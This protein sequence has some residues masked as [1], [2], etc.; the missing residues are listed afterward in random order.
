MS[1]EAQRG[2]KSQGSGLTARQEYWL[3]LYQQYHEE[4]RRYFAR[5]VTCSHDVDD[6]MQMVFLNVIAHRGDLQN[7]HAYLHAMARHQL[8]FYW[9]CRSRSVLM[10]R[11][12]FRGP[13]DS[14]EE[15]GPCDRDS[16]PLHQLSHREMHRVIDARIDGL[17]PALRE[18]L[19]LRYVDGLP[20]RAAAT[21]A[22]CSRAALKKRLARAKRLLLECFHTGGGRVDG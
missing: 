2:E 15:T 14:A 6:L 17:S 3:R 16:D 22:G 8:S 10:E 5:R 21:R 18:A 4:V 19:R 11:V 7:P 9:R 12:L 1:E 20:P 13:E